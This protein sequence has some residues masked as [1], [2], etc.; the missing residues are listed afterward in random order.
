MTV[1]NGTSKYTGYYVLNLQ[2][3]VIAIMNS[4][5]TAVVKNTYDAWGNQVSYT[6]SGSNSS[7]LYQYNALKYRGYYHDK[8]LG[9]YYLNYRYYDPA[10]CRFINADEVSVMAI[11]QGSLLQYNLYTYC[12]NNPVNHL[13]E[14]GQI[15]IPLWPCA[16]IGGGIAGGLVSAVSYVVGLKGDM[17]KFNGIDMLKNVGIGVV[18][19]AAAAGIGYVESFSDRI[20]GIASGLIGIVAGFNTLYSTGNSWS[21][22][23]AAVATTASCYSGMKIS[24]YGFKEFGT[25]AVNYASSL[26]T[27]T[28][29]KL[30][31]L[32][33]NLC[34]W[35]NM[36]IL[37]NKKR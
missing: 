16:A 30:F 24:T 21:A 9:M 8:D 18:C 2:G 19:G 13:D 1:D 23:C 25:V 29:L 34:Q 11:E 35:Q 22:L 37:R 17:S 32:V 28:F 36:I 6:A 27:G 4:S 10:I 12:L 5:G 33:V 3:D 31:Q 14:L 15:G 26:F 20:K 7:I